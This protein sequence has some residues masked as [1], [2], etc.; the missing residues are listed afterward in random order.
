MRGQFIMKYAGIA[1]VI[2]SLI[3]LVFVFADMKMDVIYYRLQI[4]EL[5][6]KQAELEALQR[7][8]RNLVASKILQNKI[9]ADELDLFLPQFEQEAILQETKFKKG[10]N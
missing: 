10:S 1:F 8:Y 6:E 7:S 4:L 2:G 3:I 5:Q 9:M